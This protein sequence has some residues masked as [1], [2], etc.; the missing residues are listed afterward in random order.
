M[1]WFGKSFI[2]FCSW[3]H[4]LLL[5]HYSLKILVWYRAGLQD[6]LGSVGSWLLQMVALICKLTAKVQHDWSSDQTRNC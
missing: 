1:M 5:P 2:K 3:L 6:A 4:R